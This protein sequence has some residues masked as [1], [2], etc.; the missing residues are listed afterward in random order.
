[1]SASSTLGEGDPYWWMPR[2]S[3]YASYPTIATP[4][5]VSMSVTSTFVQVQQFHTWQ[6]AIIVAH[7]VTSEDR[8]RVRKEDERWVVRWHAKP[9]L[10]NC[11]E[12]S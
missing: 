5:R 11:S 10:I 9:I 4:P 12:P 2:S 6:E 3:G 8:V 7:H 1:M